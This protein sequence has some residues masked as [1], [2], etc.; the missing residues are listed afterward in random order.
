[1]SRAARSYFSAVLIT[2]ANRA[3]AKAGGSR[4]GQVL[5]V[6]LILTCEKDRILSVAIR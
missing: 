5:G 2:L 3:A 1:M 6:R 4:A